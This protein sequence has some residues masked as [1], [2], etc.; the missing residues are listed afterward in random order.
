MEQIKIIENEGIRR[1]RINDFKN[2]HI[3]EIEWGIL[4]LKRW[5][6]LMIL[7]RVG[8]KVQITIWGMTKREYYHTYRH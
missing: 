8:E 3:T 2:K 4:F 1:A 7:K 5:T 6:Q